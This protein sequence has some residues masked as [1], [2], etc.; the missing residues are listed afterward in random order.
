MLHRPCNHRFHSWLRL[1][2]HRTSFRRR[3]K[4]KSGGKTHSKR[5]PDQFQRELQLAIAGRRTA[6]GI[7]FTEGRSTRAY[8]VLEWVGHRENWVV[9]NIEG[10]ETELQPEALCD[11]GGLHGAKVEADVLR[12]PQNAAACVAENLLRGREGNRRRVPKVQE[13]SGPTVRISG[14]VTV[15]LLEDNY[16]DRI[17]AGIEARCRQAS[18]HHADTADLPAAEQFVH[19]R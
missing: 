1:R 9:E 2:S 16:I 11:R 8:L 10:F 4:R 13:L 3:C 18:S 12:S 15:V 17:I 7:E 6:D 5:L 14:D 19:G